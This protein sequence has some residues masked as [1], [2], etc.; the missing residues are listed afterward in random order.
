MLCYVGSVGILR[1][2]LA[3]E[4]DVLINHILDILSTDSAFLIMFDDPAPIV[5]RTSWNGCAEISQSD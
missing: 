2:I 1:H 5:V 3:G 4:E